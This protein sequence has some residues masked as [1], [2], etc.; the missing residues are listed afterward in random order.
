MALIDIFLIVIPIVLAMGIVSLI[1]MR[2]LGRQYYWA[3][4]PLAAIAAASLLL[5]A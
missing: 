2:V 4:I 1:T 5:T 3:V